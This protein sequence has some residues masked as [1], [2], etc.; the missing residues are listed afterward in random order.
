VILWRLAG[1]GWLALTWLGLAWLG[2]AGRYIRFAWDG[3]G[4]DGMGWVYQYVYTTLIYIY[5]IALDGAGAFAVYC[6]CMHIVAAL[7]V[8]R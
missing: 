7:H 8:C 4:R 2:I 5:R 6:V 1:G 3:M